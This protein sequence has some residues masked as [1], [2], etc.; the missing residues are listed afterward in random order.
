MA[1]WEVLTVSK[2][3]TNCCSGVSSLTGVPSLVTGR[4]EPG[5]TEEVVVVGEVVVGEVVVEGEE[6]EVVVEGEEEKLG[7]AK[8]LI[9]AAGGRMGIWHQLD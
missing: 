5:S 2:V 6:E 3:A 7:G 9:T 1:A 4:D 8:K